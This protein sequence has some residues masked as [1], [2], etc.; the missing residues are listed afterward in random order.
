MT[1]EQKKVYEGLMSFYE[2]HKQGKFVPA[3]LLEHMEP[4]FEALGLRKDT[5]PGDRQHI[6]V[7]RDDATGDFVLFSPFMRE[8]RR[9]YPKAHITLYASERNEEMARCCPYIDNLIVKDLETESSEIWEVYPFLV[10]QAVEHFLPYHFD[11]GFAGRLGIRPASIL[12]MY[13]GGVRRRISYT[14]IRS[15][16]QG[17]KIDWGWNALLTIP[18]PLMPIMQSDVDRDLYLLE[19][20]LQLPVVDRHLELW[21]LASDRAAAEQA[22]APFLAK[23]QVKRLYTVMPCTSQKFREWPVERFIEMLKVIMKREKDVGLVLMGSRG[24]ATR[25]EAIAKVFPGRAISLAGKLPFRVSA[26]VV[27]LTEKY[28][29]DDTAL[30]HIAAAKHVPVL[31]TFPYPAELTLQ[32]LSVPIRFQP[33]R[34][35]AVIVLPAKA[36]GPR[37]RIRPG[38]GC[39]ED[40]PHCILNITVEKMLE[41]YKYLNKCIEERRM[42]AMVLK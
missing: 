22:L 11:L 25:T 36:A 6:L 2:T 15:D 42:A 19:Y 16:D 20:L 28:I 37:C 10:R 17:Q 9:I 13:M 39:A 8:L 38:T 40:E 32:F 14:Q 33:Y 35:P 30:M 1:E 7:A 21:T 5:V 12:T 27:G 26:E 4:I 29:G 24:D 3:E 18:V 34:V 31:T 23:K 41:G